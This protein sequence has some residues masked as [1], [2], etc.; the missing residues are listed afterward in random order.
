M[1]DIFVNP[2]SQSQL[3][4]V[5]RQ[6][7]NR[8][9]EEVSEHKL[10]LLSEICKSG[11]MGDLELKIERSVKE[12][13]NE[14]NKFYT[15]LEKKEVD[16]Y[17][18]SVR[19]EMVLNEYEENGLKREDNSNASTGKPQH[20][21]QGQRDVKR[22]I[23]AQEGMST[24][25][26]YLKNYWNSVCSFFYLTDF[27]NVLN[28]GKSSNQRRDEEEDEDIIYPSDIARFLRYS[29]SY[30]NL[31]L[32]RKLDFKGKRR[33]SERSILASLR[34]FF[35]RIGS[36]KYSPLEF[37]LNLLE[38]ML[39]NH[40]IS[41]HKHY[42]LV[43]SNAYHYIHKTL[44]TNAA[45]MSSEREGNN[46]IL[47]TN[48]VYQSS[49]LFNERGS[50]TDNNGINESGKTVNTNSVVD[51]NRS[52]ITTINGTVHNTFTRNENVENTHSNSNNNNN[53]GIILSTNTNDERSQYNNTNRSNDANNTNGT[54]ETDNT[55][56]TNNTNSTN[57]T[58]NTDGT[59]VDNHAR[60]A[61]GTNNNTNRTND[62]NGNMNGNV[63][64]VENGSSIGI[65]KVEYEKI[66]GTLEKE[67][68]CKVEE[69]RLGFVERFKRINKEYGIKI[70]FLLYKSQN[71]LGNRR[72]SEQSPKNQM[73]KEEAAMNEVIDRAYFLC[74]FNLYKLSAGDYFKKIHI[75][76]F[77]V[78]KLFFNRLDAS[79]SI[80]KMI[81][82]YKYIIQYNEKQLWKNRMGAI[83][84]RNMSCSRSSRKGRNKRLDNY[85]DAL[86]TSIGNI[87]LNDN[88]LEQQLDKYV[89]KFFIVL[90][91]HMDLGAVKH[92]YA[93]N[94][95]SYN[96]EEVEEIYATY[97]RYASRRFSDMF[98]KEL[99]SFLV[100]IT[101]YICTH[102]GCPSWINKLLLL[103][104][105]MLSVLSLNLHKNTSNLQVNESMS[106]L[107]NGVFDQKFLTVLA[108]TLLIIVNRL[109][110]C[111]YEYVVNSGSRGAGVDGNAR[112]GEVDASKAV[113]AGS[114]VGGSGVASASGSVAGGLRRHAI[115]TG[116]VVGGTGSVAGV[117]ASGGGNGAGSRTVN[118]VT[119]SFVN[120]VT[121][122]FVNGL[123][124]SFVNGVTRSFVKGVSTCVNSRVAA[125][126]GVKN[127]GP[128]MP[129][130]NERHEAFDRKGGSV[131]TNCL[132]EMELTKGY[133]L[134]LNKAISR[135]YTNIAFII[136]Y[137]IHYLISDHNNHE[138]KTAYY[139]YVSF[140]QTIVIMLSSFINMTMYSEEKERVSSDSD[141]ASVYSGNSCVT[142]SSGV[143]GVTGFLATADSIS[144]SSNSAWSVGVASV[145]I[146]GSEGG[147]SGVDKGAGD[148]G[149]A[150]GSN[151]GSRSSSAD[152]ARSSVSS[153]GVSKTGS[154]TGSLGEVAGNVQG[155]AGL[156]Q[157]TGLT[158]LRGPGAKR[159]K[160]E[161]SYLL[162]VLKEETEFNE[163]RRNEDKM[164]VDG[165]E[166]GDVGNDD[167]EKE[168]GIENYEEEDL[169]ETISKNVMEYYYTYNNIV[170]SLLQMESLFR[171]NGV[172]LDE[173]LIPKKLSGYIYVSTDGMQFGDSSLSINLNIAST[174]FNKMI[175]LYNPN[176]RRNIMEDLKIIHSEDHLLSEEGV[177]LLKK[178]FERFN[179]REE[180]VYERCTVEES[181][182]GISEG[183]YAY[184]RRLVLASAVSSLMK[185]SLNKCVNSIIG[186][187]FK[188][189]IMSLVYIHF[190]SHANMESNLYVLK[191]VLDDLVM[192]TFRGYRFFKIWPNPLIIHSVGPKGVL[193]ERIATK[194]PTKIVSEVQK[195]P[196][197]SVPQRRI[198]KLETIESIYN[199]YTSY[200]KHITSRVGGKNLVEVEDAVS[201]ESSVPTSEDGMCMDKEEDKGPSEYE[202]VRAIITGDVSLI[203]SQGN[204]RSASER[205]NASEDEVGQEENTITTKSR[206][207]RL[208]KADEFDKEDKV[209]KVSRVDMDDRP[210]RIGDNMDNKLGRMGIAD[211]VDA[212]Q[213]QGNAIRVEREVQ[214]DNEDKEYGRQN[215]EVS[216]K[217]D[218]SVRIGDNI[219][220]AIRLDN[221]GDKLGRI[222][223]N[224]DTDSIL[225]NVDN[226][227]RVDNMEKVNKPGRMGRPDRVDAEPVV[228]GVKE[229]NATERVR[230]DNEKQRND[231]ERT[232]RRNSAGERSA[233][234]VNHEEF[235]FLER[236]DLLE[237]VKYTSDL[238][239]Y[240]KTR[241]MFNYRD[242]VEKY[243]ASPEYDFM[244]THKALY[245]KLLK[246]YSGIDHSN[247]FDIESYNI[248]ILL[249]Q[250]EVI[251]C[252]SMI[253]PRSLDVPFL[254]IIKNFEL[255]LSLQDVKRFNEK[256]S[257][258][259]DDDTIVIN[260]GKG[261][262]I[263]LSTIMANTTQSINLETISN[264]SSSSNASGSTNTGEYE[265]C[266]SG[267]T[268][269]QIQ[270][271]DVVKRLMYLL[272]ITIHKY[273]QFMQKRNVTAKYL[274]RSMIFYNEY[275]RVEYRRSEAEV[276][277]SFSYKVNTRVKLMHFIRIALILIIL[278]RG[279]LI[280]S[281]LLFSDYYVLIHYLSGSY[282]MNSLLSL[283]NKIE[284][285][286]TFYPSN[287][288]I[289]NPST[290]LY[291]IYLQIKILD[292]IIK[293]VPVPQH[294]FEKIYSKIMINY[295]HYVEVLINNKLALTDGVGEGGKVGKELTIGC[296]KIKS[297]VA[298][299]RVKNSMNYLNQMFVSKYDTNSVDDEL[300]IVYYKMHCAR[301]R[302]YYLNPNLHHIS[303][304]FSF[305]S[306]YNT[307][308]STAEITNLMNN[309][310]I[311]EWSNAV[312]K[313]SLSNKIDKHKV[314]QDIIGFMNKIKD[315]SDNDIGCL[316]CYKLAYYYFHT[317]DVEKSIRYLEEMNEKIII[318]NDFIRFAVNF[319]I[320]FIKS[321]KKMMT[322]TCR[323][324]I[325]LTCDMVYN[326]KLVQDRHVMSF[327][328][329]F[330]QSLLDS[331]P[332]K[333][334][335]KTRNKVFRKAPGEWIYT[336]LDRVPKLDNIYRL[337][338]LHISILQKLNKKF[339]EASET[340]TMSLLCT[341]LSHVQNVIL[342]T[343]TYCFM[344]LVYGCPHV[345]SLTVMNKVLDLED[346][347]GIAQST[348]VTKTKQSRKMCMAETL[349]KLITTK[350]DE[351]NAYAY[352]ERTK[353]F[354][355][356][357]I[358]SE[359]DAMTT[360]LDLRILRQLHA[361]WSLKL[362]N[363]P[364]TVTA[365]LSEIF[366]DACNR[367]LYI[368][369]LEE[370][371]LENA[372]TIELPSGEKVKISDEWAANQRITTAQKASAAF[373]EAISKQN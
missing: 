62:S 319:E 10:E 255:L 81:Q 87:A 368:V 39:K 244:T 333:K 13:L 19:V 180:E 217:K 343:L 57:E 61:G 97:E 126:G 276:E 242:L 241:D 120:G 79:H 89:K 99:Q 198:E 105:D 67:Y 169:I 360:T 302:L 289:G 370:S 129:R 157:V 114:S 283:T 14:L 357:S 76:Y 124:R 348:I 66:N 311:E 316:V 262:G 275:E 295:K 221:V 285:F 32:I 113:K 4:S 258:S 209:D 290:H 341:T 149:L 127:V 170:D 256:Y 102:E 310:M 174:I 326:A 1:E 18:K 118:R 236:G 250:L 206:K 196:E 21:R 346:M 312:E 35:Q 216:E 323:I 154:V 287:E 329:K 82:Q 84:W 358:T 308:F 361:L 212:S 307:L 158:G 123:T 364:A 138:A 240:M 366:V 294:L 243:D 279:L 93:L 220:N 135:I 202:N 54:N 274:D 278:K 167:S 26:V 298:S 53:N 44:V 292:R 227:T 181:P 245:L 251:N 88:N 303:A 178:L 162:H 210:G 342:N 301:L 83:K 151:G 224:M 187:D 249:E 30:Y 11:Y 207:R 257:F 110:Y 183:N 350:A 324:L 48:A 58:D 218:K 185:E 117:S 49:S 155:L 325:G 322:N 199:N 230:N 330:N 33:L 55:N 359:Y 96:E 70:L 134:V 65:V 164:E 340:D 131:Y 101:C 50:R 52:N 192:P 219:N 46:K 214:A 36:E 291:L 363:K 309:N 111:R 263:G 264:V 137:L 189:P 133:S 64:I 293:N 195:K 71:Q 73:S 165:K 59:V 72:G 277:N 115:A 94:T 98:Y 232:G 153:L 371:I 108:S 139:L 354:H 338:K 173:E 68:K 29:E 2:E 317:G 130:K 22:R 141:S 347:V 314:L 15:K 24:K 152:S 259:D 265:G 80:Y 91:R 7:E 41:S 8:I 106:L 272:Y 253:F 201:S 246:N 356:A 175:Q 128:E 305:S 332:G 186:K 190:K 248:K 12:I 171:E 104:G 352:L 268:V 163:L 223:D 336:G 90:V 288:E 56:N 320:T 191:E 300:I 197:V 160:V 5:V 365:K 193:T 150:I 270:L 215:K 372:Q 142:S 121:R 27:N 369:P 103:Y 231:G 6:I 239:Y 321:C 222:V 318:P 144:S 286:I 337:V 136:Y 92:V 260:P 284:E 34:G 77:H 296:A 254:A 74:L 266:L 42:Q 28:S 235:K 328:K 228:N 208:D 271:L 112:E 182:K 299:K 252:A 122:S 355:H 184:K 327:T 16:P 145:P 280:P 226:A 60:N 159:V 234:R 367:L 23:I 85:M 47:A 140:S 147:S 188:S 37:S 306:E 269:N 353:I 339:K 334:K 281:A 75:L 331:E 40:Q 176:F 247:T 225:Y 20:T 344:L 349:N 125:R 229:I 297:K 200:S 304:P 156:S 177:D 315:S 282:K 194:Y 179:G 45:K 38:F 107:A 168:N 143:S 204:N 166:G 3:D 51:H 362:Y 205:S 148:S 63:E 172:A 78:K 233:S 119:R 17:V 267:G 109:Y 238:E 25:S 86:L 213:K 335:T 313:V 373:N 351:K 345:L 31:D 43:L 100:E 261:A 95:Q 211:R 116:S 161:L 203:G 69:E 9:S 146:V 237:Y 273:N 132:K